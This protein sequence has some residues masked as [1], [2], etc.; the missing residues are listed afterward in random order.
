L[1][2][3]VTPWQELVETG[4]LVVGNAAEN[5]GQPC[6]RVDTVQL[7]GFDQRKGDGGGFG[8]AF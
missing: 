6:L 5:I 4:D 2:S 3:S 1:L 7:G 8:R